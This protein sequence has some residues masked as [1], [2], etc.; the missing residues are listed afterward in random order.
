M[1]GWY[2]CITISLQ[3]QLNYLFHSYHTPKD[4]LSP[5]NSTKKQTIQLSH[6]RVF[7]LKPVPFHPNHASLQGWCQPNPLPTNPPWLRAQS[8]EGHGR[9]QD[10]RWPFLEP[11]HDGLGWVG[12]K[13]SRFTLLDGWLVTHKI[14]WQTSWW[15][16]MDVSGSVHSVYIY[17][18]YIYIYYWSSGKFWYD[19]FKVELNMLKTTIQLISIDMA[20][21]SA[22]W[23]DISP[24]LFLTTYPLEKAIHPSEMRFR[25]LTFLS[26]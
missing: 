12:L 18:I 15:K 10:V 13:W 23:L 20:S 5:Q 19:C 25:P 6:I 16:W 2:N 26:M 14:G 17:I 9:F 8:V 1:P 3:L 21:N 11:M 22:E 7:P 24:F 4:N